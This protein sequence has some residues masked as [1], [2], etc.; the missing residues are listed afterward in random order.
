[1]T[2]GMEEYISAWRDRLKS[3]EEARL[4]LRQSAME[5]A[6]EAAG[7][8]VNEFGAVR[9]YLIGSVL[10]SRDFM[11]RS[12]IDLVVIGLP[13][14]KYFSALSRIWGRL[15]KGLQLDLIPFEDAD[16]CLKEKTM[17]EGEL[18]YDKKQPRHH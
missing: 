10:S 3:D 5:A 6:R 4:S 11:E 9:V 7:V 16:D 2:E 13:P 17:S 14:Q 12:D 18:L 15:P 1:M 8:L